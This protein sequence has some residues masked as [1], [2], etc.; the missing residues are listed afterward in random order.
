M[1]T[2]MSTTPQLNWRRALILTV[3]TFALGVLL[4][5]GGLASNGLSQI[6]LLALGIIFLFVSFAGVYV[7]LVGRYYYKRH[8]KL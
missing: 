1:L 5:W 4:G 3:V 6:T 8:P 2:A 7:T